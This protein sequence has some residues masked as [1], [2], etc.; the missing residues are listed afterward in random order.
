MTKRFPNRV[1]AD[2]MTAAKFNFGRKQRPNRR[3][4]VLD[5]LIDRLHQL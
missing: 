4:A 2:R 5:L 3:T 1:A